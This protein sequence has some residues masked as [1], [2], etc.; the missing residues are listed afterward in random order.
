MSHP[1]VKM[2]VMRSR[3]RSAKYLLQPTTKQRQALD[4]LVWQQRRLYNQALEQRKRAWEE[5]SRSITRYQQFSSL[6]GLAD[7]D[8]EL[9]RYGI[10]VARGTLTRLDLAFKAFYRRCGL[11]Q[12]PGYPRFKGRY[13][14]HSVSWPD[15]SGWKVDTDTR[16]FYAMGLGH[17]K[18]RL[19]RPLPGRPKTAELKREGRRWWVVIHCDQ[20]PTRPLPA[21]GKAVGLDLGVAHTLTTSEGVHITNPRPTTR[22][23]DGLVRAQRA[24]ARK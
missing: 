19:H 20:V 13:R 23:A 5:E 4:H 21:T 22:G 10:C 8:P 3:M 11:G 16:R 17:V 2:V 18:L 24:L 15:A 14:F 1:V 12:K 6:N 7:K 9:A